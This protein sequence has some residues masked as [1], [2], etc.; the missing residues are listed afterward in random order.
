MLHTKGNNNTKNVVTLLV[1]PFH[2]NKPGMNLLDPARESL[3]NTVTSLDTRKKYATKCMDTHLKTILTH[4][5]IMF[6]QIPQLQQI[7]SW[8]HKL[9]TIS[10]INLITFISKVLTREHTKSLLVMDPHFQ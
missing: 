5:F 1:T 2:L 10:Q 8:T 7:G 9:Y 6:E 3:V 4:W